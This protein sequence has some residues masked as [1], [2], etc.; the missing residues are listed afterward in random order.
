MVTFV[1]SETRSSLPFHP[2]SRPVFMFCL[3]YSIVGYPEQ[4]NPQRQ[5]CWVWELKIA[6][7]VG[8][9]PLRYYAFQHSALCRGESAG[10]RLSVELCIITLRATL[11]VC[12]RGKPNLESFQ[13]PFQAWLCVKAS[14]KTNGVWFLSS[15]PM[16]LTVHSWFVCGRLLLCSQWHETKVWPKPGK[17]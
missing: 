7:S 8:Q 17:K 4:R 10:R 5:A 2:E 3:S 1:L 14:N 11:R 13:T 15:W 6:S 9:A 12:W 16:D